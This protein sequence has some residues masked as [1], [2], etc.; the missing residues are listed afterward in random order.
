MKA[1]DYLAGKGLAIAN[2]RGKFSHAAKAELARAIAEDN[3]TFDDWDADGRKKP[4]EKITYIKPDAMSA[5]IVKRHTANKITARPV[6][7]GANSV[8]ITEPNGTI[9]VLGVHIGG[10]SEPIKYCKCSSND[11]KIPS[12]FHPEST[13]RF[14]S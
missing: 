4:A 8:K 1:R 12:Y 11:F 13:Y 5:N 10:C 3:M 14:E 6:V 7:R 2:V 9:T